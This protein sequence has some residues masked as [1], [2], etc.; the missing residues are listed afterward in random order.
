MSSPNNM[1]GNPSELDLRQEM[2][3]TFNGTAVEIAKSQPGLLRKLNTDSNGDYILCPCVDRVTKEA[4]RDT[5]CPICFGEKYYWTETYIKFYIVDIATPAAVNKLK[6]PG[7]VDVPQNTFY[8][9]YDVAVTKPDKI[10]EIELDIEGNIVLPVKR[11]ALW[12]IQELNALRGDNGRV[13]FIKVFTTKED[14]KYLNT[15]GL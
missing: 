15:P 13:E 7:I 11:I 4:D 3:N 9:M 8:F 10:V 14:V 1:Y 5:F 6:A 12:R 2:I